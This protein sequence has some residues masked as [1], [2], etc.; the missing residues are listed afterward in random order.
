MT[1]E[2]PTETDRPTPEAGD[3]GG[4]RRR[5]GVELE[6]AICRAAYD[7]LTEE[8]YAAFTIESVAARAQTG[9]A[10]IYRRWPTKDD[11]LLDSF[12]RGIP[13]PTDCF[14]A[15]E[16]PDD[17][18]TRDALV[19]TMS[20]MMSS[21]TARKSTAVHALASEAA[22][23]R[24][25]GRALDREVLAPR[26]QG[27]LE[28]FQRGV[29]RGDVRADAPLEWVAEVIPS[30]ILMRVLFRHSSIDEDL[31]REIVDRVAIPLLR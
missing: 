29:A 7:E 12:C 23:D 20:R 5:R 22:R 1:S 30:V 16:L 25:L 24:E 27:L 15:A 21:I 17:V 2:V 10:S 13:T 9:K 31:I 11:L 8:G 19:A 4:G 28:L 3:G 18:S 6:E 26:R 14:F